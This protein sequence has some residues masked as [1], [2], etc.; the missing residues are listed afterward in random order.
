MA[1][2]PERFPGN[3]AQR[4]THRALPVGQPESLAA[5]RPSQRRAAQNRAERD[6]QHSIEVWLRRLRRG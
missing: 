6:R 1:A 3:Q 4:R 5:L 2:V